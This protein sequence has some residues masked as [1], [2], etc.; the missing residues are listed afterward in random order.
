MNRGQTSQQ[1][2]IFLLIHKCLHWPQ[3]L[4]LHGSQDEVLHFR[5]WETKKEPNP[6]QLGTTGRSL[7]IP[8][9]VPVRKEGSIPVYL[10]HGWRYK[11][12]FLIS[13]RE[14]KNAYNGKF[15]RMR[16]I[17]WD[18]F[19]CLDE[20]TILLKPTDLLK[21][22]LVAKHKAELPT[23]PQWTELVMYAV[24]SESSEDPSN[25]PPIP[26]WL[27]APETPSL[28]TWLVIMIC[29][30]LNSAVKA[31]TYI[32]HCIKKLH[33]RTSQVNEMRAVHY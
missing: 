32:Y 21:V 27:L 4:N 1:T 16:K 19:P 2:Q 9:Q 23:L 3:K 33:F 29:V 5:K 31:D 12:A 7:G 22:T 10:M 8:S 28:S 17:L 11:S 30:Q 24:W 15:R 26:R 20:E 25:Y 18:Y 13:P 14:P 6:H